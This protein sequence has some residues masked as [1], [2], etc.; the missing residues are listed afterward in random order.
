MFA[1]LIHFNS[2]KK[3]KVF[4]NNKAFKNAINISQISQKGNNIYSCIIDLYYLIRVQ[5]I[6]TF[7]ILYFFNIQKQKKQNL[8]K[9]IFFKI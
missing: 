3:V 8:Q 4:L 6:C 9:Y 5:N 1:L 2:F 7:K